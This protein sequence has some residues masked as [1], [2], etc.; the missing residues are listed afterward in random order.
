MNTESEFRKFF[1]I[2]RITQW[3]RD[4]DFKRTAFQLPDGFLQHAYRLSSTVEAECN[5]AKMYILADTSY[6]RFVL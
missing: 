3:I 1:E 2:E 5:G 6:R 4:N